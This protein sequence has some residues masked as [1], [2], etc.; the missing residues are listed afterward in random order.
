MLFRSPLTHH[1]TP[2]E[3]CVI[4]LVEGLSG[5]S[6]WAAYQG[7]LPDLVERD[8]VLA[9]VSLSSGQFNLGRIIGP[10]AA[11]LALAF[12]S[13]GVCFA[14]NAA[15]FVVVVVIFSFVRSPE[16]EAPESPLALWRELR[17]GAVAA[18]TVPGCRNPIVLV[19]VFSY[20]VSPFIALIP[21]MAIDVLHSGKT[22]TS[23]LVAAQGV[24]AVIAVVW[25]PNL[26]ARTSRLTVL[27]GSIYV[28]CVSVALYALAPT[29]AWA[30]LTLVVAGGAYVGMITGFNSSVQLHA[31]T[32]LRSRV[33]SLYTMSLSIWYPLGTLAQAALAHHYGIRPVTLVAGLA[34]LVLA[35]FVAAGERSFLSAVE[36]PAT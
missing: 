32:H 17:E 15:S 30:A 5:S 34:G 11:G 7:L 23:W 26:A 2:L 21:A 18:R 19:S 14:I 25:L 12:G 4:G 24:G 6:S 33:V 1:L 8:E 22:G 3:A 10:T 35:T 27:R 20:V 13:P 29:L 36:L 16:R 9:A 28:L 31:P